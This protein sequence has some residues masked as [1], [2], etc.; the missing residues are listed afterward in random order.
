MS[1][2]VADLPLR[3]PVRKVAGNIG[4]ELGGITLVGDLDA[5]TLS[6]I[7]REL[8]AHKVVFFRGQH[9]LDEVGQGAFGRLLGPLTTAHPTVPA[10]QEHPNVLE[11]N[12][13]SGGRANQ[14]H[15]DV[16]FVDRP[17]A[18]SLLRAVELP[19]SGG[20]TMWA[21]TATGYADLPAG[22]QNLA[23]DLWAIHSNEFDYARLGPG[24]ASDDAAIERYTSVFSAVPFETL[25]PVVRVHPET[26][27]RALLLGNFARRIAG[28]SPAESAALIRILQDRVTAP[29]HVVRWSWEPGDVAIWDNRATQHYAVSD[30]GD[31]PRVMRR[32]TV[33]G[34]RPVSTDGRRSESRKGDATGYY[35]AA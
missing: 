1:A 5:S 20:D 6:H 27:E 24:A 35:A 22:L 10:L 7:R 4:A 28:Y 34:D 29:E 30:Y 12:S 25:H 8:L 17:P 11:V 13:L 31:A 19:D 9:Q 23:N 33:S 15:T 14:W 26:G 2:H 21:N 16:T 18:F 3:L 32:I